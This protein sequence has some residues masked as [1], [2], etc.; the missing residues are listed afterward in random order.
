MYYFT[1]YTFIPFATTIN[2]CTV[3]FLAEENGLPQFIKTY[4]H[5]RPEI[6]LAI[7]DI[8]PDIDKKNPY[9]RPAG[10]P[11]HRYAAQLFS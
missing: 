4:L 5:N 7:S 8:R 6:Q 2:N 1:F 10:Y 11:V 3:F 9:L